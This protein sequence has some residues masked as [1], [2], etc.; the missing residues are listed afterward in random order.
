MNTLA[1]FAGAYGGL[2]SSTVIVVMLILEVAR[3]GGQ[4]FLKALAAEIVA[5]SISF[6]IY[7]A[8]AGAVF[9]DD[10]QVPQYTFKDWQ[11]L[12]GVLLGLFAAL[13]VTL[14]AGFMMGAAQLFGRLKVPAIAKSALGGVVFGVVGV[15]LPLTMFSGS[16][17]LNS[18]L[19][20]AGTLGLGL[21]VATLIAKMF[22]F[23]VSQ[24]SGFVGGPIFPSLFIGGTTGVIVHQVIP[25]VPLGLAFT[26]LLAAVP[27]ALAPAPF[28][29]V[30]MAAFLTQVGALQ[31]APILIAVVT[32]F[33]T[34]EGVKYLLA[35]R[36]QAAQLRR[37]QRKG[38]IYLV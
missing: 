37:P 23:A 15:A 27:G 35:S 11:L 24:G 16:N 31:T 22:T 18:V 4:R 34:M 19:K 25:S 20:D 33:L 13:V 1:G 8:I 32:A 36:K 5:S 6:G 3:P 17:Q 29:M 26:C 21:L 10:Y 28:S 12:A 38:F 30:L 2:F 7:F 14:L 9:L